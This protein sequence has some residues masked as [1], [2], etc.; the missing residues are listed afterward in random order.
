T[1]DNAWPISAH[2]FFANGGYEVAGAWISF[3]PGGDLSNLTISA[4]MRQISGPS[5]K[6][7]GILLRAKGYDQYYLFAINSSQQWTFALV[8]NGNGT[9]IVSPTSDS[10][11]NTGLNAS[12]TLTV[13]ANG[14][15]FIFYANGVELGQADDGTIS[16]GK[17]GLM[18]TVGDLAVV[19][20]DFQ[21]TVPA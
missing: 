1:S 19:Y 16:S 11:I 15:H 12:N 10:H 2:S 4:R 20:N 18:D 13:R 17:T 9:A 5:D 6:F 3:S 7:Y 14:K 21:I 8:T